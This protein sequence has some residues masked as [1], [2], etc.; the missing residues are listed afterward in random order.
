MK[1]SGKT[2]FIFDKLLKP[3]TMNKFL[4]RHFSFTPRERTVVIVFALAVFTGIFLNLL[5]NSVSNQVTFDYTVFDKEF[6]EKSSNVSEA[7]PLD[8]AVTAFFENITAEELQELPSIGPVLAGRIIG[9]LE[10]NDRITKLDDLLEVPGI[11]A[12]RLEIIK[13]HFEARNPKYH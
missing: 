6:K 3:Q 1:Y 9:F 11:G 5:S 12:K 10:G 8:T 2:S 13:Q 7:A 4:K